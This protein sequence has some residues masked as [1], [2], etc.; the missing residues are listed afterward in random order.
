MMTGD[1]RARHKTRLGARAGGVGN[2]GALGNHLGRNHL[3]LDFR[4]DD[5]LRGA[6]G[7]LALQI[8]GGS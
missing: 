1:L 6:T 5:R 8:G 7:S 2:A 3:G 4:F